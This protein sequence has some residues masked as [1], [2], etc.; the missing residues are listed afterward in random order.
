MDLTEIHVGAL[1]AAAETQIVKLCVV[2][3][4]TK[5][6][7]T[8]HLCGSIASFWLYCTAK[9]LYWTRLNRL[10][11]KLTQLTQNVYAAWRP[12]R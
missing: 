6:S 9:R 2:P 10:S 5:Q 3:K 12:V 4:R 7:K 11:G 1:K 8:L